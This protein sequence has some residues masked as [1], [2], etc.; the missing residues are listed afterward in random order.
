MSDWLE[1]E[2]FERRE[3]VRFIP[4]PFGV[5]VSVLSFVFMKEVPELI[6]SKPLW[7]KDNHQDGAWTP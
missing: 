3:A 2:R 7:E 5:E 4:L 6:L 1:K